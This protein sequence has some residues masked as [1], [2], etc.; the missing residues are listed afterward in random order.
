M[1]SASNCR[2]FKVFLAEVHAKY[3]CLLK[4]NVRQLSRGQVLER[5]VGLDEIRGL[6]SE[7]GQNYSQ[8]TAACWLTNI[9]FFT[10]FTKHFN[11]LNEKLQGSGKT[12]DRMF[13]D[14]KTFERKLKVFQRDLNSG[15]LKYFPN[16]KLYVENFASFA[17]KSTSCQ[18]KFEEFSSFVSAAKKTLATGFQVP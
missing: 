12:A 16:L 1:T 6:M 14:I 2:Q 10:N 11:V 5:F 3:K 18:E 15:K 7:K 8:L 13:C 9:I 17:D 4:C